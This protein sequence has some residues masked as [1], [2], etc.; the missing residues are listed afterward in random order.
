[1]TLSIHSFGDVLSVSVEGESVEL[2]KEQIDELVLKTV[3]KS[4]SYFVEMLIKE[5]GEYY[6]HDDHWVK[7]D[8]ENK[9]VE[10]EV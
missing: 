9:K 2:L 7:V 6:D 10:Y 4:G 3:P 5:Y 8:L 1:M